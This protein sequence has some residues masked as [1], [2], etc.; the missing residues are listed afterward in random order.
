MKR[1]DDK[2]LVWIG[3]AL[4]DI[5]EFPEDVKNDIGYALDR[6]QKGDKPASAKPLKGF[7]GAGVLEIIEDY[8]TDTYRAC[9]TVRFSEVIYVLHCFQKKSKKGIETAYSGV[10]R[11]PF[12]EIFGHPFRSTSATYS[13]QLRPVLN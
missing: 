9:Y 8:C 5:R 12:P 2:K 1:K 10:L 6:V 7:G 13:G 4:G 11:P 3:S